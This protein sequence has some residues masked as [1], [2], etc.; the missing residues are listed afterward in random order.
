[1]LAPV[2]PTRT[3]SLT[4]ALAALAA[5]AGACRGE[6]L[7]VAGGWLTHDGRA[8]WG[9]VQHNGWWRAGQRPN[10][11]RRSLGDP[12]GDVRPNRTEDLDQLTDSMLRYGYPGFEHNHGLWY[13]RRRD[14]HDTAPR[15]DGAVVPPFLE[16]PWARSDQGTASDGLPLYD[17]TRYNPWYF[18]RLR[19]FADLCDRK[20]TV[21]LH[22]H[23]MQ[24]ALLEIDPHYVDFPWRPANCMQPTAMPDG[25]PAANAYYDVSHPVRRGL[26]RAYTRRCL[27]AT[28]ANT[29][30][31]HLIGQE[32]T[33]PRAFVEFWLDTI[34]EWEAESGRRVWVGL[35]GAK[36]VVDAVLAD[37]ERAARIDLIDLRGWYIRADGALVAPPGGAEIPGRATECGSEQSEQSSP[38]RLYEKIR[39]YRDAHPDKVLIDA[40]GQDRR[41]TWAAFMAGASLLV[42]GQIEYPDH[43]DPPGYIMPAGVQEV[44]PLYTFLRE[45][46]AEM[47]PRMAPDDRATGGAAGT[48]CLRAPGETYL[49]YALAG[50]TLRL[51][52]RGDQG[53]YEARWLDPRTGLLSPAGEER[54]EA[55]GD[56]SLVAPDGQDWALWLHRP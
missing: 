46:L 48:W 35:S 9:W 43:A 8:L 47:L 50:G 53:S 32:F 34:R 37:P 36:D 10:L 14:A 52:L 56:V 23:H 31:I 5:G 20:G 22:K 17:L 7:G 40:I 4:L 27:E 28:A 39:T 21:L 33:G 45:H 3:L 6:G 19:A 42:A 1:M 16:Q 29:N 25:V 18:D 11:A 38:E 41:Q 51:D 55:G 30:V 49:F 54:L 44:L 26:H 24:H 12:Q 2:R 13:D 15:A